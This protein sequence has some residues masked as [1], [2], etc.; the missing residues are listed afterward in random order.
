MLYIGQDI[1]KVNFWCSRVQISNFMM[2]KYQI[3]IVNLIFYVIEGG[4]LLDLQGQE[5]R[6]FIF[7]YVIV[8]LNI[9][10]TRNLL[11]KKE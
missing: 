7:V 5:P 11:S 6:M 8:L 2:W 9:I 10:S 3:M 1:T 4:S